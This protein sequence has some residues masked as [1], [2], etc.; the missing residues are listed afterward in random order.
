MCGILGYVG[1][2]SATE[3]IINGLKRLEY[4]GYDSSGIALQG[5][6]SI[7]LKKKSGKLNELESILDYKEV[8]DYHVG[9]GHTRWA[10]HGEP[11]D[12]NAHPHV[13]CE[14]KIAL[15]HNGIIENYNDL[16]DVLKKEGHDFKSETDTEVIV[17]LIEHYHKNEPLIDSVVRALNRIEGA[18]GIVVISVKEPGKV[19]AARKGSPL[20]L[21]VGDDE[22]IIASDVSAI[23]EHTRSVI[24]MEDNELVEITGTN[25]K[26]YD[27]EKNHIVKKVEDID[28]DIAAMEKHGFDHFMLKEIH[29]QVDTIQNAFRGRIIPEKGNVRLDG[30]DL[31]RDE[32]NNIN[33][34]VF[35]ACGTSWHAALIGKYMLEEYARIAVEVEY[36]SEFRYRKPVLRKDDIVITISQSGETADTLAALREAK[37]KGVKVMGLTNVVGSTIARESEG[38]VYLHAGPEVGVASTK[39]FTSQIT[40]LILLTIL[41]S[42]KR[43]MTSTEAQVILRDLLRVPLL[44]EK[45]LQSSKE[46]EKIAE[47]YK[48]SRNF[49][50]LGRGVQFPVALEGA[51]KLKEISYIH[52]EGYPAAEMKHGPIALIDENMPVVFIAPKDEVYAKVVSN[53]EEV[54][55]RKGKII[56]IATEGDNEIVKYA[57]HVIY[58]P[59]VNKMVLPLL[60]VIPLQLLSY[61]IAVQREC[62]VDQPR[63]LAKSVTVE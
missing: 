5:E 6:N 15:V 61:Y 51:L 36:A 57:D 50:Y 55:A 40:V 12:L 16:R 11:N 38:G 24:Y 59:V 44:V 37:T 56:A 2:K 22:T 26:T 18:Y 25:I 27:L 39:A 17:H 31:T 32:F 3:V 19:I 52:A 45:I 34:I 41:F 58:V 29:E 7:Y 8:E 48:D 1:N 28:W 21:G 35:I 49:L 9:I 60:T 62:D 47:L 33:R 14:G 53:I 20:I 4:R 10:T 54:R 43:D 13:D 63:N 42:R 30:F 46:I 23:V